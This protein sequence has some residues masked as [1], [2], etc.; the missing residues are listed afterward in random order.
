MGSWRIVG[1]LRVRESG[2]VE[3]VGER[4]RVVVVVVVGG[5]RR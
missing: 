5:G 2:V 4:E 3:G 1:G